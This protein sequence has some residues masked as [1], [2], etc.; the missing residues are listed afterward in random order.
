MD[1]SVVQQCRDGCL[2]SVGA[3]RKIEGVASEERGFGGERKKKKL[4]SLGFWEGGNRFDWLEGSRWRYHALDRW[5]ESTKERER[6]GV[7]VRGRGGPSERRA[8]QRKRVRRR[9]KELMRK[10]VFRQCEP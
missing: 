10:E 8:E 2:V 6:E 9:R 7:R 5:L 3:G 4:W 1:K